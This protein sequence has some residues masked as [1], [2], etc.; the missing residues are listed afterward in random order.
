MEEWMGSGVTESGG[1]K[2]ICGQ[3]LIYKRRITKKN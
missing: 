1:R 2:K 3:D